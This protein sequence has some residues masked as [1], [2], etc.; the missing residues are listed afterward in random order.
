MKTVLVALFIAG[1]CLAVPN[2]EADP[3][4]TSVRCCDGDNQMRCRLEKP[5]TIGSE[6]YCLN[7]GYGKVC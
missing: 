7:Q 6:C 4:K 2:A 3:V 1:I 5:E